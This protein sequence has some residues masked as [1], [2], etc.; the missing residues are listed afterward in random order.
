VKII[1]WLKKWWRLLGLNRAVVAL[2]IARLSDAVGNSLLF[3]VLPLYVKKT[4]AVIAHLPLPILVGLLISGY[5]FVSSIFQPIM[6]GVSDRWG[7]NKL[8]IQIG[9]TIL[10]GATLGFI[11][12]SRYLD[13]LLLRLAQGFGLAMAVPATM[14]ILTAVTRQETR[15]GAMGFYSTFRMLGLTI[16]PVAGGALQ[17]TIGFEA[18]FIVGAVILV[19]AIGLV[20]LLVKE[21]GIT[22]PKKKERMFDLSLIGAP[23]L[24][25]TFATLV[26][27]AAFSLIST[28]E[29]EFNRRL[30]IGAFSFG[31]AF[32]SLM[33]GQLFFQVPIGHW[34]D[35]FGRKPFI[36]G[37][38]IALIPINILLGEVTTLW[39]FAALRFAEGL[40]SA[41]IMSPALAFASD[42]ARVYARGRQTSIVTMGFALGMGFG[43]LI[44]GFLSLVFFEF[45]F[46][47][48]AGL[49]LIAAIV[50]AIY[51]PRWV[52]PQDIS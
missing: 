36:L 13:L 51:M 24:S 26:M 17:E 48:M 1:E 27:S 4:P 42:L 32:S 45:P 6:G 15:G 37:G 19:I 43:P 14:S 2:S 9:L 10:G 11:W 33:V 21:P 39:E 16:G 5:G 18:N 7:R 25:A 35:R 22:K 29:N 31:I 52:S 40:S 34:S 23:L 8:M 41:A 28:L 38:L 46:L 20:Q 47:V 30:G 44:A 50:V 3:V 49:S 12:A